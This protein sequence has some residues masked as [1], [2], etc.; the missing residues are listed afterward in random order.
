MTEDKLDIIVYGASGF[1]GKLTAAYL[2]KSAPDDDRIGLAGRSRERLEQVRHR[3]G[4]RALDWPLLVADSQDR[5][6]L[7]GLAGRATVIATT[8]G[9]YAEYGLPLV[10]AC[11][12]A[13]THYADLTGEVPF[14]RETIDRFDSVAR[15]SGARI[16]HNAGFDSIPSDLGVLLLHDAVTA[17]DAGDLERTTFVLTGLKGGVSGGTIASMQA[18][19]ADMAGD[20]ERRR[21]ALDA[22]ALS[23]HRDKEPDDLNDGWG[24]E[25]DLRGVTHDS[26]IGHWLAPFVMAGVNTRVVRRSNALQDWAYG[27]RFRYRE[28]TGLGDGPAGL[29]KA[30]ALT[31]GLAAFMGG[32]LFG[33]TRSALGRLL[34]KP[35][36]GP[37]EKTRT[38]GF[39]RIEIHTTTSTGARYVARVAAKGDPGYAATAVMLGESALSLAR[40]GDRLPPRA[41][42]LT[43][44]TGIGRPL[45]DRLRTAGMTL[46]VARA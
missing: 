19:I 29:V 42:V 6:A 1:V 36:E 21:L 22:Y 39:F 5:A 33:P 13:G 46:E 38:N 40:D 45:V 3:L 23:P 32:M 43:P 12:E 9:P 18:G 17:D 7:D 41:G 28:V 34:P 14:M 37:S 11:A 16:V 35:G 31:G 25:G 24:S 44:A 4:G 27:R 2:A 10:A 26:E 20:S 15:Q 8:V 30:S